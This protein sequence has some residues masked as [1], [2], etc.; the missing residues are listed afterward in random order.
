M[1]IFYIKKTLMTFVPA[2]R[3]LLFICIYSFFC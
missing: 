3:V 1:V 2:I